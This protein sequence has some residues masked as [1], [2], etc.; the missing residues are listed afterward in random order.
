VPPGQVAQ[1]DDGGDRRGEGGGDRRGG[2][3]QVYAAPPEASFTAD[4]WWQRRPEISATSRL[5]GS[6][7]VGPRSRPTAN[8]WPPARSAPRRSPTGPDRNGARTVR[9]PGNGGSQVSSGVDTAATNDA[10]RARIGHGEHHVDG[11]GATRRER[12]GQRCS[13]GTAGR[14]PGNSPGRSG[15]LRP[16][17][18][19]RAAA[20]SAPPPA[21][22]PKRR[23][24]GRAGSTSWASS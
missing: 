14:A 6:A 9:G 20:T 4:S 15:R 1:S 22:S 2:G 5:R 24:T 16:P 7:A 19:S 11:H 10:Q 17:G 21:W 12:P 18:A 23:A 3:Q 13:C 8:P